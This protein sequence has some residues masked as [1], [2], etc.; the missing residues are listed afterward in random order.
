VI[1]DGALYLENGQAVEV[2]REGTH[3]AENAPPKPAAG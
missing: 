2:L 3:Q 1:T